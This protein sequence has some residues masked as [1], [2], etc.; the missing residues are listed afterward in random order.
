MKS[1]TL[2]RFVFAITIFSLASS[3]IA[4]NSVSFSS[5]TLTGVS[6]DNPTSLQFGPDNRLYVSQQNGWI[7]AFT[8]QRSGADNYQASAVETIG[9]IRNIPNHNDDGTLNTSVKDRQVTGILLTGTASQPILYV[10]SSDPRIGG[11]GTGG[12]KILIPIQESFRNWFGP[13][14]P[15]RKQT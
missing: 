2:I 4:Q 12:D 15:G 13:E 6:L 5:S 3:S 9:L 1:F 8:I 14:H 7:Y 11:G 10:S